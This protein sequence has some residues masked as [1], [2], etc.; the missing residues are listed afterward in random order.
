[1]FLAHASG[2]TARASNSSRNREVSDDAL[3]RLLEEHRAE[4]RDRIGRSFSAGETVVIRC[5]MAPVGCETGT[6][7]D[8]NGRTAGL[9][10]TGF[11][12]HSTV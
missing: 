1:M 11:T 5:L 3:K 4:R 8:V 6:G 7:C 2:G 10:W 12:K 9:L